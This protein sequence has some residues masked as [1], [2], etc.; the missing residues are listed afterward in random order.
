MDPDLEDRD[1]F[2]KIHY[3]SY[4]QQNPRN[5][6]SG[7]PLN[8][9]SWLF[10][11]VTQN[12]LSGCENTSAKLHARLLA[13][14]HWQTQSAK[15][16]PTFAMPD[17][18]QT[19]TLK[20]NSSGIF[21]SIRCRMEYNLFQFLFICVCAMNHLKE[22]QVFCTAEKCWLRVLVLLALFV[23]ILVSLYWQAVWK[24]FLISIFPFLIQWAANTVCWLQRSFSY[25]FYTG[26]YW[27]QNW[28]PSLPNICR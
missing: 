1:P 3:I 6:V 2:Q 17:T 27:K 26:S 11:G 19:L 10:W 23:I 15:I 4:L 12:K 18:S 16:S 21:K 22:Q 14:S 20:K 7:F 9:L 8:I 25:S 24:Y 5:I 28:D 13:Q